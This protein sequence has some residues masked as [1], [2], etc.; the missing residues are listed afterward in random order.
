MVDRR[1]RWAY[2]L[3]LILY[4]CSHRSFCFL[5]ICSYKSSQLDISSSLC[6]LALFPYFYS[7]NPPALFSLIP[8]FSAFSSVPTMVGSWVLSDCGLKPLP[9]IF[10]RPTRSNLSRTPNGGI[11]VLAAVPRED[12]LASSLKTQS[13]NHPERRWRLG[14]SA[15]WRVPRVSV[16]DDNHER[17]REEEKIERLDEFDTGA[18]PPFKL[19]DIRAAIPKHC[20]AKDPW[21]SMSYVVRD[22]AAVF[23]LAVGAAYLNNW[24]VWPLYWAAQG[25]M[26]WALFVVGHDWYYSLYT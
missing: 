18:P 23:A 4:L 13:W 25:T 14:V 16:E 26:F 9:Q 10:P 22:I 11:S 24:A 21:R 20:W 6:S 7:L 17:V 2:S 15:P 1:L 5:F 12:L 19:A 3:P 8:K